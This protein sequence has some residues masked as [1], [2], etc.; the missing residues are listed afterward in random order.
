MSNGED[1]R[2]EGRRG[3]D[4]DGDGDGGKER[5][6]ETEGRRG[7]R[8]RRR[9]RREGEGEG[10]GE[11]ESSTGRG[12]ETDGRAGACSCRGIIRRIW[13]S[14][15]ERSEEKKSPTLKRLGNRD[16]VCV[17][18]IV[19]FDGA[20][21]CTA[22]VCFIKDV[23]RNVLMGRGWKRACC[24]RIMRLECQGP[25]AG[26]VQEELR[27]VR[28][29]RR[30]KRKEEKRGEEKEQEGGEKKEE[31]KRQRRWVRKKRRKSRWRRRREGGEGERRRRTSKRKALKMRTTG[32]EVCNSR[33]KCGPRQ[34]QG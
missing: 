26:G 33:L 4:G 5:A 7:R 20:G 19:E 1:E 23:P 24:L 31:W 18:M 21:V 25:T 12:G 29:S 34:G 11:G 16:R 2:G 13:A 28:R 30:R 9:R 3:G 32:V 10:E 15:D 17:L 6:T 22:L 8:R 14:C 27:S